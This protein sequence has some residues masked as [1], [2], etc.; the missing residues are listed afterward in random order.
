M[1]M[2]NQWKKHTVA[3]CSASQVGSIQQFEF[4]QKLQR[5]RVNDM[6]EYQRDAYRDS[7]S[8]NLLS[9]VTTGGTEELTKTAQAASRARKKAMPVLIGPHAEKG[10]GKN[11]TA[12]VLILHRGFVRIA[13]AD[14]LREEVTT[15]LQSGKAPIDAPQE[16]HELVKELSGRAPWYA[17]WRK[18]NPE[19]VYHK[20]LSEK[21][22]KF[23]QLWG[24]EFRRSQNENYWTE[25]AQPKIADPLNS[26]VSV[27][28]TQVRFDDETDL[29]HGM[30][31]LMWELRRRK[32]RYAT[33]RDARS[34]HVFEAR[35]NPKKIGHWIL[36]HAGLVE[37]QRGVLRAHDSMRRALRHAEAA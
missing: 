32:H 2:T 31:G 27:V 29:T 14:A 20:P 6:G 24:T 35:L 1:S 7:L 26:G 30:G 21:M 17:F 37:L 3:D 5:G 18:H 4:E 15:A 12:D 19:S 8:Q 33:A 16:I 10:V 25:K 36:N 28:I 9:L 34:A 23:Q 11:A 13:C 22:R